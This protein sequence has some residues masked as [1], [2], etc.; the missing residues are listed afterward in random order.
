MIKIGIVSGYFNP[1]HQ[2]H[3]EYI[4]A[5]KADCDLLFVIVNNDEQVTQKGSA[6][7]M[8]EDH[9]KFIV[10]NLK[11][12]D[13]TIVSI[14]KDRTVCQSIKKIAQMY[15]YEHI[16]FY[17]SGDR[18]PDNYESAESI[19]CKENNIE[20]KFLD[21]PKIYSSSELKNSVY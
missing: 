3:I 12:V 17:N 20:T 21:L 5:A 1:I 4:N 19:I 11:G 16:T 18:N 8:D 10:S 13:S 9:R 6:I 15:P 2:G 14:D 7:F